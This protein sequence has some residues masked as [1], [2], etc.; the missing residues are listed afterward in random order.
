MMTLLIKD[1]RLQ[2]PATLCLGLI[3]LLLP[4][5]VF[6]SHA[7]DEGVQRALTRDTLMGVFYISAGAGMGI[8][9]L[10]VPAFG[11]ISFAR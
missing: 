7:A 9:L 8:S 3:Y 10:I 5:I 1:W 2:S 11:G 4:F 6:A